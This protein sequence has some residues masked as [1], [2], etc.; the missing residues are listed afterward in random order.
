MKKDA[1]LLINEFDAR[2]LCVLPISILS[3]GITLRLGVAVEPNVQLREQ[4]KHCL[5]MTMQLDWQ[6]MSAL[7]VQR[8]L[9]AAYGNR[10]ALSTVV[11][12]YSSSS[13]DETPAV[14]LVEALFQDAVIRDA[15]DIHLSPEDDSLRI[16][17]RVAGVLEP[18]CSI[19]K[20]WLEAILVRIKVLAEMNI[21]ES[22]MPQDGLIRHNV[23]DE[24]VDF[25]VSTFP[26]RNGEN[27]VVRVQK[28]RSWQSLSQLITSA[29]S[30]QLLHQGLKSTHGL[31]ILCGPT[32]S[33]K[34]TTLY[35]MLR[36]LENDTNHVMTLEDPVEFSLPRVRQTSLGN[37]NKMNLAQAIRA[38]LRQDP[39]V[40]L[41]G[42][43]RD[44]ESV[45][46]C[47]RATL[48][49]RLM[50]STVHAA[51]CILALRR[52]I[53][54]SGDAEMVAASLSMVVS[55][56]LVR[57]RTKGDSL[58]HTSRQAVVEVLPITEAVRQ[59]ICT[60]AEL[61]GL[62]TY[63]T[64]SGFVPMWRTARSLLTQ[65]VIEPAEFE[66]VFGVLEAT[67]IVG[68]MGV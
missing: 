39:D 42:E 13:E 29:D 30:L 9:N 14:E 63:A 56:R 53:D 37:L 67:P 57:V 11:L 1:T 20:S 62:D 17:F 48:S 58:N 35:A 36:E 19:T 40:L 50:L 34:T 49:G 12:K 54:L 66:R 28:Q 8:G 22:R 7:E 21:A 55:Q 5:T 51:N 45:K 32:G 38:V 65:G 59:C 6:P 31:I 64:L 16:R 23:L 52:L 43:L 10:F 15:S 18:V 3:D 26:V 24:A 44:S 4:V 46:Q 61:S 33:G 41:I 60:P 25:R 27:T 68:E 2:R 47:L